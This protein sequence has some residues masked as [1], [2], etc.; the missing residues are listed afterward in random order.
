MEQ[1]EEA[2]RSAGSPVRDVAMAD[3]GDLVAEH[4]GELRLGFDQAQQT[5]GDMHDPARRRVRVDAIRVQN[6][7]LPIQGRARAGLR[8]NRSDKG[9]VRR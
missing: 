9:Y 1:F 6:D 8:E 2:P 7:E 3:V 4:I 5:S